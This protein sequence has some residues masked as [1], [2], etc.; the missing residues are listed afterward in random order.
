MVKDAPNTAPSSQTSTDPILDQILFVSKY[1]GRSLEPDQLCGGIPMSSGRIT[2]S[3]LEE[4]SNRA[5]L[6][7]TQTREAPPRIKATLLPALMVTSEGDIIAILD[8]KKDQFEI[9]LAGVAGS[10]WIS[11]S[12]LEQSAE[13]QVL[14]LVRPVFYFDERSLVY[15][16]P[17]P[18]L[19]FWDTLKAN[20][21]IY[22]W[23]LIA[24][25]LINIFGAAIP[26][27]TMA[28][29]DRVVPNNSL[30][31]LWVLAIA[32]IAV[33]LFDLVT[34]V[35]RS[36]LVDSAAR[37]SDI[38]L[39]SRIFAK[40]LSM[41][42]VHRPASGG[43]LANIVRDFESVRD[44]FTSTT[45]TLLGDLPFMLFFLGLIWLIGGQLVLVP[46]ALIPLSIGVSMLLRKPLSR[47]IDSQ[48]Q[49][50]SQ[51]TAHLFEVMNGLDTVKCQGMETWAR[52]KWEALGISLSGSNVKLREISAFG[53]YFSQ[54]TTALTTVLLVSFGAILIARGEL[55]MGQLIAVSMLSA[56]ALAPA[57][58][59]SGLIVRWQQTRMSLQ[60]LNQIMNAPTDEKT[61]DLLYLPALKGDIEL[62]DLKFSYPEAPPSLRGINLK[63]SPGEKVAF[64][65][66]IGSGK[67]TLLKILL[68]LYEPTEG[69]ALID[70]IAA[71][72]INPGSLRRAIGYVPQDIVLFHGDIRENIIAG[73]SDVTDAEILQALQT[74]CLDDTLAQLPAGLA[75][76]VGERGE[77]LSGGQRQAIAIARAIVRKPSVLLLDEP[78]SM[79]DPATENRLIQNLKT[80]LPETTVILVTHRMAMLPMTDR[81]VV[82][83][84]GQIVADGPREEVI[85]HLGAAAEAAPIR[86]PAPRK[87]A[88]PSSA[89]HQAP[90]AA[91]HQ[92][93]ATRK[94]ATQTAKQEASKPRLNL[95][96][97]PIQVPGIKVAGGP[98]IAV[99]NPGRTTNTKQEK[100]AEQR[101]RHLQVVHDKARRLAAAKRAIAAQRAARATAPA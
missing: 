45:L 1:Y 98:H 29:Y 85:K 91:D 77:R 12:D 59:L 51:R 39:S 26:F 22:G 81:L 69:Q 21:W 32:A 17:K 35:M 5:G 99:Q 47:I 92:A 56:R 48:S 28:V 67:S 80:Q 57:A 101:R 25:V 9:R 89:E 94:K 10:Q 31:S 61:G 54:L 15:Q 13:K 24:T 7:I 75:T 30:D 71:H 72:Q 73:S 70:G 53:G 18:H 3:D 97:S 23:A 36:Y 50:S 20:R 87:K 63:L 46:L 74:A 55:T 95:P 79:M 78:S 41:R 52:R 38:S 11:V 58:Q 37:K 8:R 16:L 90:A 100:S 60:A 82:F 84:Q 43:V 40:T 68:N 76:Q 33:I 62:R 14:Y 4:L 6:A 42:A 34:K 93:K 64:I 86:R 2:L 44:F 65:G 27:F 88:E 49:E 66:R 19:W 83:N 96:G